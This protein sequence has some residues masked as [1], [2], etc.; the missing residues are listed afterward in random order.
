MKLIYN[1]HQI[2]DK[3]KLCMK[4]E[5]KER[6][7]KK[8]QEKIRRWREERQTR[9]CL[10]SAKNETEGQHVSHIGWTRGD[11]RFW[12]GCARAEAIIQELQMELAVLRDM[13]RNTADKS[14]NLESASAPLSL[15]SQNKS[16]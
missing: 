4:I 7:I 14:R 15:T 11:E 10:E 16:R 5:I 9:I 13:V 3:C 2:V 6:R 1:Q 12:G 8:E